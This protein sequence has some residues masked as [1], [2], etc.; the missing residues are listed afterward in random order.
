M[1][2]LKQCYVISVV[3][4]PII[5]TDRGTVAETGFLKETRALPMEFSAC[6]YQMAV[7]ASVAGS[8]I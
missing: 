2:E 8:C 6:P 4:Y 5:I 7:S 3:V 1:Y